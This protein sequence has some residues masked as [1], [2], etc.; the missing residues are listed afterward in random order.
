ACRSARMLQSGLWL[1]LYP[2]LIRNRFQALPTFRALVGACRR[3]IEDDQLA[4]FF[5]VSLE[6]GRTLFRTG[7]RRRDGIDGHL[8]VAVVAV[9]HSLEISRHCITQGSIKQ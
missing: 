2:S 1:Q 5:R 6:F 7:N 9:E 4:L 8:F 3:R